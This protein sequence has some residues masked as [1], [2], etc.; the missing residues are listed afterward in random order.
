M[1]GWKPVLSF[2]YG[3]AA[4]FIEGQM[5]DKGCKGHREFRH[6]YTFFWQPAQIHIHVQLHLAGTS[7]YQRCLLPDEIPSA[8][9]SLYHVSQVKEAGFAPA[10]TLFS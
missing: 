6:N 4:L 9:N 1:D 3:K 2:S 7:L 10:S 8:P 5:P